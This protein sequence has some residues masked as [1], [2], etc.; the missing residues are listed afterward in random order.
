VHVIRSATTAISAP[1]ETTQIA[2]SVASVPAG[3]ALFLD[4]QR[5]NANPFVDRKLRDGTTHRLRVEAE[6]YKPAEMDLTYSGDVALEL[7]LEPLVTALPAV[8]EPTKE[9][10]S[11]AQSAPELPRAP[12]AERPSKNPESAPPE[13]KPKAPPAAPT[14][15]VGARPA[16]KQP[17]PPIDTELP[18]ND[19]KH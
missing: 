2:F 16:P 10:Q 9:K 1:V 3:A 6:Q 15:E 4:G 18:W 12:R 17:G 14:D 8:V 7:T 5:L 11:L 13:S 19:K